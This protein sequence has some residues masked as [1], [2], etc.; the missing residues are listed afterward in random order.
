MTWNEIS[1]LYVPGYIGGQKFI[2]YSLFVLHSV[3]FENTVYKK[4]NNS[5][6]YLKDVLLWNWYLDK[7]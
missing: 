4:L 2:K 3:P 1:R 6:I 7:G 5:K